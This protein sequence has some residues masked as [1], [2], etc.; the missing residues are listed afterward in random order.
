MDDGA[1]IRTAQERSLLTLIVYLNE[2]FAGGRTAFLDFELQA[3][4][5]T[6]TALVFQHLLLH[7]GCMVHSGVKYAMRSDVMYRL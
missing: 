3:T 7:E 5:K 2:D 4:P 1:Y 6:G